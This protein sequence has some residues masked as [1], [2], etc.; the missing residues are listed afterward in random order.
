VEPLRFNRLPD[1]QAQDP[2]VLHRL[3]GTYAMG[4]IEVTVAQQAGQVLTISLPGAPPF[5]LLP[6]RGLR[7][8]VKG[9]PA[10]TVEFELDES[11]A[12]RRLVAQPVGIFHPNT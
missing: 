8:D 2:E 10:I 5:E 4:P 9:Q 6:G 3:C 1:A 11:G 12:V 7:F